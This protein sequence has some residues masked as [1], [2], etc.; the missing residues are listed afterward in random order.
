MYLNDNFHVRRE[1]YQHSASPPSPP[2]TQGNLT[3]GTA[4]KDSPPID[5]N[6]LCSGFCCDLI[7]VDLRE[8]IVN[9]IWDTSRN[10][11]REDLLFLSFR[12]LLDANASPPPRSLEVRV[13][14]HQCRFLE[15]HQKR[16]DDSKAATLLQLPTAQSQHGLYNLIYSIIVFT[17]E[18]NKCCASICGGAHRRQRD[19]SMLV[20]VGGV[21]L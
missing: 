3:L 14:F 16:R 10:A 9:V 6:K 11:T 17:S 8:R 15:Y 19:V 2:P 1:M 12:S 21:K 18:K 5:L 20:L 13:K 4:T 7:S